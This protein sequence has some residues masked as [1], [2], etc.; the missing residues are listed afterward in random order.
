[1][2]AR[3]LRFFPLAYGK[4]NSPSWQDFDADGEAAAVAELLADFTLEVVDWDVPAEQRG[5]DSTTD[6]LAELAKLDKPSDTFLYCVSHGTGVGA[7]SKVMIAGGRSDRWI[8]PGLLADALVDLL[9]GPHAVDSWTIVVVDA[10]KSAQFVQ[11]LSSILSTKIPPGRSVLLIATT[12]EGGPRLGAFREALAHIM[13]TTHRVS[14]I[15]LIDLGAEL[16]DKLRHGA[17]ATLLPLGNQVLTRRDVV[18]TGVDMDVFP[19]L[20]AALARLP[21]SEKAHFLPK[22]QGGEFN[23]IAWYFQG[24]TEERRRISAWLRGAAHGM[25]VVTGPAGSGKSALLGNVVE[26]SRPWLWRVLVE[27][28]LIE[29]VPAPDRPPDEVF[30]AV[31]HLTGWT[32]TKLVTQLTTAFKLAPPA[33]EA[34]LGERVRALLAALDGDDRTRTI[35]ID[36]LDEAQQ[37]LL[38]AREVIAPLAAA[39]GTRVLVGTRASTSEGPDHPAPDSHDLIVALGPATQVEVEADP[40]AVA[41]YITK[42]L[43]AQ[44]TDPRAR[45]RIGEVA[46]LIGGQK[47]H[48]LY[49]RL[50]V[51]ELLA[52]SLDDPEAVA[53]LLSR[54]HRDLFAVAVARLTAQS[55]AFGP[56]LHALGVARGRGL[57]VLGGVWAHVAQALAPGTPITDFDVNDLIDAA[58][59]YI[60]V[61]IEHGDTVYRLSHATFAEHYRDVPDEHLTV[62]R[63]LL[64]LV[65]D[66]PRE[67]LTAYICEYLAAHAA[68]A[69]PEA[70][71][72]LAADTW[73]LDRLSPVAVAANAMR[74]LFG[75][76]PIPPSIRAVIGAQHILQPLRP[77]ER[78][79]NRQ[80]AEAHFA[81]VTHPLPRPDGHEFPGRWRVGWADLA[82]ASLTMVLNRPQRTVRGLAVVRG[83]GRTSLLAVS[84]G[85]AVEL[86]DP[87]EGR[88]LDGP[89]SADDSPVECLVSF[90]GHDGTP[91]VVTAHEDARL[92]VWDPLERAVRQEL[93]DAAAEPTPVRAVAVL[94]LPAGGPELV[95]AHADGT[96]SRWDPST[97]LLVARLPAVTDQEVLRIAAYSDDSGAPRVAVATPDGRVHVHSLTDADA[98]GELVMEGARSQLAAALLAYTSS[99]G[100]AML[101]CGDGERNVVLVDGTTLEPRTRPLRHH[102]KVQA[103]AAVFDA[104]GGLLLATGG[105]N[106]LIRLWDESTGEPVGGPLSGHSGGVSSLVA[107]TSPDGRRDMLTSGGTD[108]TIRIWDV[109]DLRGKSGGRTAPDPFTSVV[110]IVD[111]DGRQ[112]VVAA[113]PDGLRM[114]NPQTDWTAQFVETLSTTG[115]PFVRKTTWHDGRELLLTPEADGAVRLW[116]PFPERAEEY[117][118][119]VEPVAPPEPGIRRPDHWIMAGATADGTVRLWDGPG[120]ATPLAETAA[121]RRITALAVWQ[122]AGRPVV[123]TGHPD[124]VVHQWDPAAEK[125]VTEVTS[126]PGQVSGIAALA[127]RGRGVVLASLVGDGLRLVEVTTGEPLP[128]PASA[129]PVAAFCALDGPAGLAVGTRDGALRVWDVES[130]EFVMGPVAAHEGRLFAVAAVPTTTGPLVATSGVD[131]FVRFWDPAT[132]SAQGGFHLDGPPPHDLVAFP[133]DDGRTLLAV[134]AGN[135]VRVWAPDGTPASP[136]YTARSRVSAL[137]QVTG[138]GDKLLLAIGGTG[139]R[140]ELW[141]PGSGFTGDEW[142]QGDSKTFVAVFPV[143][144]DD[145]SGRAHR[146]DKSTVVRYPPPAE[147]R[148]PTELAAFPGDNPTLIAAHADH[149]HV[150]DLESGEFLYQVGHSSSVLPI[151]SLAGFRS[152]RGWRLAVVRGRRLQVYDDTSATWATMTAGLPNLIVDVV[153]RSAGEHNSLLLVDGSGTLFEYL[154]DEPGTPLRPLLKAGPARVRG[155]IALEDDVVVTAGADGVLDFW[156]VATLSHLGEIRLETAVATVTR[157]AD[158]IVVNTGTGVLEVE[159]SGLLGAARPYGTK[160]SQRTADRLPELPDDSDPETVITDFIESREDSNGWVLLSDVG[161]HLQSVLPNFSPRNHGYTKLRYLIE[162]YGKFTVVNRPPA[163]GKGPAH[164]VSL[165]VPTFRYGDGTAEWNH[166][167]APAKRTF[168]VAPADQEET[169]A[170]FATISDIVA[171]TA[172]A[173]GWALLSTVGHLL[174]LQIPDFKAS[175]HGYAKLAALIESS[176]AFALEYRDRDPSGVAVVYIRCR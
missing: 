20:K 154:P 172:D 76:H 37:P 133:D 18:P 102:S 53:D 42:R 120:S 13:Q 28:E 119:E 8:E 169:D 149:L 130:A 78:L 105:V 100:R 31:I 60:T 6:R 112:R 144:A 14:D 150:F 97:G 12:V 134:A 159:F 59:P 157:S 70:W 44:L 135:T 64:A 123:F 38:I 121:D 145:E 107:V 68:I 71:R 66:D 98:A 79:G 84:A 108:G 143:H 118:A 164:F 165:R 125:Q 83:P 117:H 151:T 54:D 34:A 75:R 111:P 2:T 3:P 115:T 137:A 139:G 160:P 57:P 158:D 114:W 132:G 22:A 109:G 171:G 62:F 67:Q 152:D 35:L 81:G 7:K 113:G 99:T 16:Q 1:M 166:P 48:F 126:Y 94:E 49:A 29:T 69:G 56:L 45:R 32:A 128:P 19:R 61:D 140:G 174:H 162:S 41:G 23:E 153:V 4:Y 146:E 156:H 33:P 36:A 43:R 110:P 21:Q 101:A 9:K 26:L 30:D 77:A 65:A 90:T 116:D 167:P 91:Y 142:A 58:S 24:R 147:H 148:S 163:P 131:G 170:V 11:A 161:A 173:Q 129:S 176:D 55:P 106:Q 136:V 95:A 52:G 17:W 47:R 63:A 155:L 85:D 89:L 88:R 39:R 50:A 10:C 124:G 80:L 122:T 51:H 168:S 96:I 103:V 72:E 86:W 82:Q 15:R 87:I 127:V 175:R 27:S 104:D 93:V 73:T 74:S 92:L 5:L 25:L 46:E 40:A 138:P 141:D